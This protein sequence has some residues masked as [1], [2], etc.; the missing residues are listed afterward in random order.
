MVRLDDN[1]PFMD[2]FC[3]VELV[4]LGKAVAWGGGG[5]G[6]VDPVPS[7]LSAQISGRKGKL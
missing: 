7:S 5:T 6:D 2:L 1:P 3:G 4:A